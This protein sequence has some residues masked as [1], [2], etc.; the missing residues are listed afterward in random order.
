[1]LYTCNIIIRL[2]YILTSNSFQ[3]HV[4]QK[5][6][7]CYFRPIFQNPTMIISCVYRIGLTVIIASCKYNSS[8]WLR[9]KRIDY[10]DCPIPIT[11]QNVN[12]LSSNL[13]NRNQPIFHSK[14]RC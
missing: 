3:F 7:C 1:M 10:R 2:S 4:S 9:I 8:D 5:T 6:I 14:N 12:I 13:L 11:I